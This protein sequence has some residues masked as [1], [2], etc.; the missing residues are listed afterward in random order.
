MPNTQ[1]NNI[2]NEIEQIN[3][4]INLMQDRFKKNKKKVKGEKISKC[5]NAHQNNRSKKKDKGRI[6]LKPRKYKI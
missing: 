5:V 1:Q 3:K 4:E 6:F 2:Q